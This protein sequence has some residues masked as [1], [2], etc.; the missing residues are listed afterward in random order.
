[1]PPV[2]PKKRWPA[3]Q[4]A[5]Q[6]IRDMIYKEEH[7]LFTASLDMLSDEEWVK[8]KR[9]KADIGFSWVVPDEGWPEKIIAEAPPEPAAPE[10]VVE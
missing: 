5:I 6:T 10:D 2:T 3:C 4:E 8:V 9:G 7:I 1:L